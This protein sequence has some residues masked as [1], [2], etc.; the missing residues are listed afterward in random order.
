MSKKHTYLLYLKFF[1]YSLQQIKFP[2]LLRNK[3]C[4][5]AS[6]NNTA[7]SADGTD[8]F[9]PIENLSVVLPTHCAAH[10]ALRC[11]YVVTKTIVVSVP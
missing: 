4:A 2:S 6:N 1:M 8:V 7:F 5:D 10:Q 11:M 3:V 9:N